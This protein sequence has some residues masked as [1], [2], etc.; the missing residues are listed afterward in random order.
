[1]TPFA[2]K[3][4]QAETLK[5]LR[6]WLEAARIVGA[7]PAFE[8]MDK[9]GIRTPRPYQPLR[10]M[11]TVPYAC[12]RLPTGGG[13]T[14][15]SAH[16][17]RLA[18][19]AYLEREF[20]L[21]LWLVP[22]NTIRAQTLETLRTPG[23]ANRE[24]LLDAFA[25]RVRV[26]DI[27]DFTQL[28]P[29]DLQSHACIIVGTMQT[30]RVTNPDGRRVYAHNENLEPHFTAIPAATPGMDRYDTGDKSG[31]IK[32]S[33]R[34]I[35]AFHRPLVIVDEAHNNTSS[36]SY[37]VL[38]RINAACVVEFTAT[39]APD[40]NVLH[41]V[42]A[43]ELKAEEMIKLPIRLTEHATW[44]GA[45][46]DSLLTRQRLAGFAAA[47]PEYIRPIIL[48]QAEEKGREV[49][50]EVLLK[51]LVEQHNIPR[52]KIAIV[53]GDQKELDG[54]N[55]FARDC[56]IDHVITVEALKEGWDCS[57]AYV[58]CSA[59]TVHSKRD[60]EQILGR[61]LR[62]P[63]ARRR[64]HPAL[65]R[66]YAHV[67]R[68]SWPNA[69][70]Q[71]HDHLVDMGFEASEADAAIEK[72]PT[73]PLTGGT[74]LF[75]ATPPPTIVELSED[76]TAFAL[77]PA[78]RAAVSIDK[79]AQGSR[80]T[81]TGEVPAEIVTRLAAAIVAP[82]ARAD[83]HA[84][85]RRHRA[86]WQLHASPAQRDVPFR[87]PQLCFFADGALEPADPDTILGAAD[88]SLLDYPA[89]LTA[90]EFAFT[91]TG[92]QWEIDLNA[93]GRLTERTVARA[94]QINLELADTGWT[95]Q[96]LC[97]W[98]ENRVRQPYL[99]Q[100]IL[101]EFVRRCLAHLTGPRALPLTTLVRWKFI[102]AR[103]LVQKIEQCRALAAAGS[104][105][106]SLFGP[107][108]AVETS[109]T[110]TFD[111]TPEGYAPHWPY[112]GQPYQFQKH[113]YAAIGELKNT[114][115]EYDCAIALDMTAQVKHW[116]RN[117][118][119]RGFS[120]PLAAGRFYPDFIAELHDGRLLIVE[121]K[122]AHL[123]ADS[124]EKLNIGQLWAASSAGRA[125]FVMTVQEKGR[126]PLAT[127][128]ATAIG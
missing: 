105:Q 100:T 22:T 41:N 107:Q 116:V 37:E 68:A 111:F 17:V 36:L 120:L 90:D 119:R 78:E 99:T 20:P 52:N 59:A 109:F 91:E 115:E 66:A 112:P 86:I 110:Y 35:L 11:P 127:Q 88:W 79:T 28:T 61:V 29:A 3:T 47:D 125:I 77:T 80:V 75:P 54:I 97:R 30:L 117:L 64:K 38:Q 13:K 84:E 8:T 49:T 34:N 83:L 113:Y 93:A 43:T 81:F 32:P 40:S 96:H 15:L 63:Y 123:V 45:V 62:M 26:F 7:K 31:R 126:P 104:Y 101:L 124:Q 10:G 121:H 6:T 39:P 21:V 60:V 85:A 72:A 69:V 5:T 70:R 71:L 50:K 94:D 33:F 46:Q 19:D 42:A 25:G 9:P 67:A 14:L 76:L 65:N 95:A 55:L 106:Q 12:L 73:L 51:H 18:A 1:M 16:T 87:V 128:I 102:L 89:E 56:P 57:F 4:Y 82:D 53:T 118:E 48:F 108:A 27:A 92:V 98:L 103:V 23:N 58:F 74:G 24:T 122:G 44:E 114:G 2:L